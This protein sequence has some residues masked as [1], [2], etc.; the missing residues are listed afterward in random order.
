MK[1]DDITVE[2]NK[3]RLTNNRKHIFVYSTD[4]SSAIGPSLLNQ[5]LPNEVLIYA[6]NEQHFFGPLLSLSKLYR[7]RE[8]SLLRTDSLQ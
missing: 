1:R 7:D 5:L 3:A 8:D 6:E 4:A 2:H